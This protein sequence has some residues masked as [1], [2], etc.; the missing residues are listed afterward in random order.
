MAWTTITED[1]IRSQLGAAELQALRGVETTPGQSDP[2]TEV[3][4]LVVAQ[5]RSYLPV[6]RGDPGQAPGLLPE[7]LHGVAVDMIRHRL[8]TR[9]AVGSQA[10]G[11]LNSAPRQKA[12]EEAIA[13][14]RDVSRG[15]IAVE[16][17]PAGAA[18]ANPTTPPGDWGSEE[19]FG[20]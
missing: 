11:W 8:G 10:A 16:A 4:N 5:T 18:P 15:F 13:Y 19:R 17:P 14:L 1:S 2:L 20:A 6:L 12:Y 7:S 3:I 9:L